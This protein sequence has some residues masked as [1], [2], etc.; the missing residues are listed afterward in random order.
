MNDI[1]YNAQQELT[2]IDLWLQQPDGVNPHRSVHTMQSKQHQSNYTVVSAPDNIWQ[3]IRTN[4]SSV[5]LHVLLLRS[6]SMES[7][8]SSPTTTSLPRKWETITA[9]HIAEGSALHGAVGLI[10]YD[11][12]PKHF[13]QRYLL[14]D[15]GWV[16][17]TNLEGEERTER[18]A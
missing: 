8:S 18:V 9:K 13:K 11:K 12:V 2:N 16:N 17:M 3:Q 14:S 5:Y 6:H 1:A 4:Q 10:K 7:S 15:F